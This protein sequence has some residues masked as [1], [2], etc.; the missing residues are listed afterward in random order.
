M[1]NK[2][3]NLAKV[4]LANMGLECRGKK[5]E[6]KIIIPE[7]AK[8]QAF[9]PTSIRDL[10]FFD[11]TFGQNNSQN[12][13][14]ILEGTMTYVYIIKNEIQDH[15][16]LIKI[17]NDI[18]DVYFEKPFVKLIDEETSSFLNAFAKINSFKLSGTVRRSLDGIAKA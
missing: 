2:A 11:H 17:E 16:F 12:L 15:A 5:A 6:E 9:F 1:D 3:E 7:N 13:E 10:E 4:I 8:F 18:I 14:A